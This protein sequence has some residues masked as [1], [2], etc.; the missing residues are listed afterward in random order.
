M[1][2]KTAERHDNQKRR[3][4]RLS[5]P[6]IFVVIEGCSYET[7]DWSC[8]GV[9]IKGYSGELEEHEAVIV[10]G[11]GPMGGDVFQVKVKAKVARLG[12]E[13]NTLAVVFKGLDENVFDFMQELMRQGT[14]S[15]EQ[16]V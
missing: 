7:E 2:Y 5:S 9:L 15:L 11:I 13:K 3:D 4:R 6:K 1:A 8:G 14:P 16:E 10:E 12:P